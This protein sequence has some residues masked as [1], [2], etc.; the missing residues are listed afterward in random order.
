[1]Q[2][3]KSNSIKAIELVRGLF[4]YIHGNLGLLKFSVDELTALNGTNGKD[5]KKWKIVC[6]FYETIGSKN[7]T[8]YGAHVDLND[9]T[10]NIKKISPQEE[11]AKTYKITED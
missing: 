11:P 4:E 10:V 2:E 5:S 1:M 3:E 9:N 8:K 7:P 6:S